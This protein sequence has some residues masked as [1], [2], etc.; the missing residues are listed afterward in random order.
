MPHP[1][2]FSLEG[3]GMGTNFYLTR[4]LFQGDIYIDDEP[5]ECCGRRY[6]GDDDMA[7]DVHIGKRSAAGLYCWDCNLTLCKEGEERIHYDSQWHDACPQC[8]K[9][10]D[11]EKNAL[12]EG[13][14]AVELG[15]AKPRVV[16]PTGV[17]SCSSFSWAQPPELFR[18]FARAHAA[19]EVVRDEYGRKFMGRDFLE[20]LE[21]NC[22]VQLTHFVGDSFC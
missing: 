7:P 13:S 6:G 5:C 2:R 17:R 12:K 8:G 18:P 11:A 1:C 3:L 16:K 22:P 15:F 4:H 19:D 10:L 20:M 14:A 21:S 9:T